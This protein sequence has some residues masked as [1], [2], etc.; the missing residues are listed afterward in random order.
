MVEEGNCFLYEL[1]RQLNFC[2]VAAAFTL[3][4]SFYPT[5]SAV[6]PV[7]VLILHPRDANYVVTDCETEKNI[8]IVNE[9]K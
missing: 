3:N 1:K 2:V 6:Y 7:S 8:V 9:S 5:T 4:R